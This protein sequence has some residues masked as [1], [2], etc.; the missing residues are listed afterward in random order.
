LV[1]EYA[2][3][4]GVIPE[5]DVATEYIDLNADGQLVIKKGYA[6]DG[7]SGPS[8]DTKNFMRGSLIHDALY[9]LMRQEHISKDQWRDKADRELQRFCREDGMTKIRAWWVYKALSRW[10]DPAASPESKKEIREA[11]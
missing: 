4:V 11:P 8:F 9:Q 3:D 10:G 7:P 2:V 1:D 5:Q 6:W